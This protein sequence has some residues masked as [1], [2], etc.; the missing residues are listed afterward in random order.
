M[1]IFI[2]EQLVFFA[3]PKTA[4]TSIET[5]LGTLCEIRLSKMPSLK[6]T[7]YRKY[8]RLLEPFIQTVMPEEPDCVAAFREP[9][10]WLGSWY[11]Y[12]SRAE[13][14]G[15]P[16]STHGITFDQFVEA[17]LQDD[18]PAYASVGSQSRFM[19]NKNGEIGM[20]HIFKYDRMDTMVTFLSNRL[21]KQITLPKTN[22][23]PKMEL[24]LSPE[25]QKEFQKSYKLDFDIYETIA[26]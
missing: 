15:R 11:R 13:L 17:Y 1:L 19:S 5:T 10:D 9:I 2:K 6:H 12:R 14:I 18:Q 26:S 7:P 25:L 22:V 16:N 24:S 23:S 8:K 4:S 20:T 3:T 21:K